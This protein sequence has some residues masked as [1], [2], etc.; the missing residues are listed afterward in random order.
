MIGILEV[1]E[2]KRKLI[3]QCATEYEYWLEG[4]KD[5][6]EKFNLVAAKNQELQNENEHLTKKAAAQRQE[7]IDLQ[8][9][10]EKIGWQADYLNRELARLKAKYTWWSAAASKATV[11]ACLSISIAAAF[12]ITLNLFAALAEALR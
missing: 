3:A 12:V 2:A 5:K 1:L 6:A 8:M 9:Q 7:I 11:A 10:V 4:V